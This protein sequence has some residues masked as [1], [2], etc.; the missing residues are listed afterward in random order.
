MTMLRATALA[1][2]LLAGAPAL[3]QQE[4]PAEEASLREGPA[5]L[6]PSLNID[7]MSDFRYRGVSR[8][9]EDPAGRVGLTVYHESGLYAGARTTTLRGID[10]YRGRD[11]G[12]LQTDLYLGYSR[13]LGGG[14]SIDGGLLYYLVAGDGAGADDYAEPY[15]SLSYLIGPA[16]F[17]AGANY[18]PDQDALGGGDILY[19]YGRADVTVPFRP[20][21][22]S[23]E[24][25]RQHSGAFGDYWNWSLGVTHHLQLEGV[26]VNEIGLRYV[27][28]SLP[29]GPG[30]D[31]G[32]VVTVNIGF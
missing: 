3:A 29:G 15:A 5:A 20:W 14:F 9:D 23:A 11:L 27:D 22:F 19:L 7:L 24:L 25:G 21:A 10:P 18:A 13:Q 12:D 31:A 17:T 1:L 8:S 26:P 2:A 32:L 6:D 16:T 28:T 4:P 30:R